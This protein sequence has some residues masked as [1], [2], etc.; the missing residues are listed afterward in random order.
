MCQEL[1]PKTCYLSQLLRSSHHLD[2]RKH[3]EKVV[4]C[5]IGL[6]QALEQT[7]REQAKCYLRLKVD[8]TLFL[9]VS[10][11]ASWLQARDLESV[12]PNPLVPPPINRLNTNTTF[13]TL[14]TS[15]ADNIR[16]VIK[17]STDVIGVPH[18]TETYIHVRWPWVNL[19]ILVTAVS[20]IF[21]VMTA[22]ASKKQ[23][24][25]LWKRSVLPPIISTCKRTMRKAPPRCE[26]FKKPSAFP[27]D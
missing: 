12:S 15:L 10:M 8:D 16:S 18:E 26:I 5:N 11:L 1:L 4:D 25:V 20:A 2:P 7:K 13:A 21:L 17:A 22:V 24:L 14:A 23:D 9:L 6:D 19:P 3:L 27:K